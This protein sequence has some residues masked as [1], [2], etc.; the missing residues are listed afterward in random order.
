MGEIVVQ[1][2]LLERDGKNVRIEFVVKDTGIGMTPQQMEKLF[3]SFTQADSSTTRKYGGT[4]LGLSISRRLVEMMGGS[5]RVE[6]EYG[7]GSTFT[8]DSSFH[9]QEGPE[10][11]LADSI[12]ELRGMRVLVVDDNQSSR[13]ILMDMME[14]L[15]FNVSVCQSGA[16]AISELEQASLNGEAYDLVLMDW[17]MPGMDGLEASGRIKADP[18]LS[19]TPTIIMVTAYGSEELMDRADEIGLEGFLLKPVSPSTIIDTL[20]MTFQK[21]YR[22]GATRNRRRE[23]PAEI[24]KNIRGARIL[25]AEDNDLNQQVAIE[26]LE[27]AG[28]SVTLAID[29]Q[30]AVE[31]MR[32]D[33]HAVLMDLQMPNM[34]GYDATRVIR[35]RPEFDGIPVI[36]MTANAME[37]DL[38]K[39]REAGMVSH[40]AKPVD[41]AR[42]YKTLAEHIRPDPV[43]PFDEPREMPYN[44]E[45]RRKSH[46]ED[47]VL[48]DSLPGVDITDG[49]SHLAGN[50]PA[51]IRILQQFPEHQ[52]DCGEKI[53][54]HLSRD[55]KTDAVRLAHSLKS[56]AGNIGAIG[57]FTAARDVEF[58]LKEDRDADGLIRTMEGHLGKVTD[59]LRCWEKTLGDESSEPAGTADPDRL[60]ERTAVLEEMLKDDDTASIEIIDELLSA[61]VPALKEI[62]SFMRREADNYDLK[63]YFQNCRS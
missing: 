52:G 39:A 33:F 13:Q 27:G 8:F 45:E 42:L 6:S 48:P 17:K 63:R 20:M 1:T 47:P 25:L 50:V 10:I 31:K 19:K 53:R 3:S 49:L 43:K 16:E 23:D 5:I 32:P 24:I 38:E 37:Q 59:G 12:D 62:L 18:K 57:L 41:P 51:Y 14:R 56:V 40:V 7:S 55:E 60:L 30:E 36:A 28:L 44:G 9:V 61:G 22:A 58:A 54:S 15:D 11:R 29:G 4:G 35:S 21:Q 46:R 34:D 2:R 26:L